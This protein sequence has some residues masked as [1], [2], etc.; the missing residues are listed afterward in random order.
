[1]NG[2][3]KAPIGM[4]RS[5][6][7]AMEGSA[8]GLGQ[9][10]DFCLVRTGWRWETKPAPTG[11]ASWPDSGAVAKIAFIAGTANPSSVC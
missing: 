1:M 7:G 2:E 3:C 10:C 4:S 11:L 9:S 5:Q 6:Q 8:R